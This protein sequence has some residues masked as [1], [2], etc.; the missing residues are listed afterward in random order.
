MSLRSCGR[1][2][3]ED[4]VGVHA[5]PS[6]GGSRGTV[7]G[8]VSCSSVWS[9][10]VCSAHIR[11]VRANE[12]SDAA[13]DH[14]QRGGGLA[15]L[16]LTLRHHEGQGLEELLDGLL[17]GW[18]RTIRGAPWKRR[19][20]RHGMLGQVRAVEVTYGANGWH[21]HLHVLLFF[22][23]DLADPERE[24]FEGWLHARWS[25]FITDN[26]LG[27]PSREHGIRLQRVY[28]STLGRYL[29]K[30]QDNAGNT[31][32]VG[33]EMAR[34]DLKSGRIGDDGSRS[35]LPFE[36]LNEAATGEVDA[37]RLWWEYE[38]A[39]K[40][41]RCMTWSRTCGC[42]STFEGDGH[43]QVQRHTFRTHV[44]LDELEATDEEITDETEVGDDT[45]VATL[46]AE[47]WAAICRAGLDSLLLDAVEV[48]GLAGVERVAALAIERTRGLRPPVEPVN[49]RA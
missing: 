27:R 32:G 40:G 12:I 24:D 23:R 26:G 9:C 22:D 30:V 46:P 38:T 20:E 25:K 21:P 2:T 29:A 3:R 5:V 36:I 35:W 15:M 31:R 49:C 39:T 48:D 17:D 37:L 43:G 34:G 45:L 1:G 10:P 44:G 19:I 6:D 8:L 41:R 18:R 47:T 16:T 28:H 11:Q 33:L 4:S 14:L 42:G 13:E 7:T